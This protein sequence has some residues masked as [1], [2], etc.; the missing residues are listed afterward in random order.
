MTGQNHAR[1]CFAE[2]PHKVGR[3]KQDE[4]Q[5]AQRQAVLDDKVHHGNVS[6]WRVLNPPCIHSP[7]H[8]KLMTSPKRS[9]SSY[10]VAF[11]AKVSAS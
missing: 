9:S 11:F 3:S 1:D 6:A 2:S 8:S 5:S 10:A 4:S 7:S